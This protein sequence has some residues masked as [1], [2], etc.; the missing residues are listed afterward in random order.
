MLI[1]TIYLRQFLATNTACLIL[2]VCA[3][4]V[5]WP[6]SVNRKLSKSYDDED[7]IG[8]RLDEVQ[9]TWVVSLLDLGNAVSPIFSSFIIN[10]IGRKNTLLLVSLFFL[11]TWLMV[12]DSSSLNYIYTARFLIG[13]SK[14]LAFT[15]VPVYISEIAD[16]KIRG[17]LGSTGHTF[18]TLGLLFSLCVGPY[19]SY[20]SLNIIFSIIPLLFLALFVL[21]PETPYYYIMK[22]DYVAAEKSLKWFKPY[23][24]NVKESLAKLVES[25]KEM[26]SGASYWALFS[27]SNTRIPLMIVT[28]VSFFQRLSGITALVAYS[29]VTLPHLSFTSWF[30]PNECVIAFT[31]CMTITNLICAPFMDTLSRK[32]LLCTSIFC[33]IIMMT[34]TSAYYYVY[35]VPSN[36]YKDLIPYV[37]FILYGFTYLGMGNV[38]PLL[39]SE[40]FT[41][42]QRSY[43]SAVTSVALATGSF[44]TSKFYLIV[45]KDCGSYFAFVIF[46]LVHVVYLLFA[47]KLVRETQGKTFEEIQAKFYKK[48]RAGAGELNNT[49]M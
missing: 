6:S 21:M 39:P 35:P 19:I 23:E 11:P 15:A 38:P 49:Q 46:A 22:E 8:L 14:G 26:D 44:I 5:A 13:V 27:Q 24:K 42:S 36:S 1:N 40:Y 25:H 3:C 47:S 7:H 28:G 43:A 17:M 12:W 2:F 45:Q 31:L 20:Q 34:L 30:G 32:I 33:G 4:W 29:S 37:L 48:S 41:T 9:I 18:M 16:H 10:R